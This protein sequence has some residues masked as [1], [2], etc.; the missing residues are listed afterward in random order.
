MHV[1][2]ILY[3]MLKLSYCNIILCNN[4]T[5]NQNSMSDDTEFESQMH[6][7]MSICKAF[8]TPEP[9]ERPPIKEQLWF[10]DTIYYRNRFQGRENHTNRRNKSFHFQFWSLSL[11][12]RWSR[13]IM[14]CRWT[15]MPSAF[16]KCIKQ[17]INF[18][19]WIWSYEIIL[20]TVYVYEIYFFWPSTYWLWFSV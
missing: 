20:L 12:A 15:Y 2:V 9:F 7:P 5:G 8:S 13:D 14:T 19:I 18:W 4:A 10:S 16:F 3:S 6:S 11:N 1:L 17:K